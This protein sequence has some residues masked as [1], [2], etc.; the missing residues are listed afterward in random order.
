MTFTLMSDGIGID[1]IDRYYVVKV[2]LDKLIFIFL[3]GCRVHVSINI[4]EV[5]II[6]CRH[7]LSNR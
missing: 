7:L 1:L 4:V 6:G 2:R 5:S 3:L